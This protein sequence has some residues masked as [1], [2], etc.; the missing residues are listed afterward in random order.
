MKIMMF[1]HTGSVNRGCEAIV[2]SSS[3]IIKESIQN[4]NIKLASLRPDTDKIIPL[5]NDVFDASAEEFIPTLSQ[6]IKAYI[7]LKTKGTD[8]YAVSQ[9]Y[10]KTIN[11]IDSIDVC[12]SIGGDNYC[13]GEQ[14]WLYAIDKEIK[15]KGKKLVLWGC[16]IGEEDLSEKKL[17]DLKTFDLILARETLTYEALTKNGLNNVK[18]CSD[19]AFVMEVKELPLPQ[20]WKVGDTIGLNFSPLVVKK[21]KD[22]V[23]AMRQLIQYILDTTDSVIALTP[24]VIEVG[25]DDYLLLKEFY[26]EFKKTNRVILLPN[27]LNATEYKGYISRMRLFIGARTHATIA[28]YSTCVPTMVLGYSVKS[29]GIAKDLFG[30]EKLVLGINE[31]SNTDIL[32][33]N[34]NIMLKEEQEIKQYLQNKIP[35]VKKNSY[36]MAQYLQ[37]LI[38]EN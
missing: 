22:S 38:R 2:R 3:Q 11:K 20:G 35:E 31:L 12:L 7:E 28:A 15:K 18:L 13:Y 25:N 27:N 8:L 17:K 6:K 26:E 37:E 33:K 30:E 36:R 1:A 16:S 32:I 19:P 21:N 23:T 10:R 5:V 4:S 14:T 29:R 24:H 9:M 34:F